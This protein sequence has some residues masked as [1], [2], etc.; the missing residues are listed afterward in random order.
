M[1]TIQAAFASCAFMVTSINRQHQNWPFHLTPDLVLRQLA[2]LSRIAVVSNMLFVVDD[3]HQVDGLDSENGES[4][5]ASL[6]LEA[7]E[8]PLLPDTKCESSRPD[9]LSD[10]T[11]A[12]VI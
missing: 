9:M 5:T 4:S 7:E 6:G 2:G 11:A 8:T 10:D 3:M 12:V 1:S